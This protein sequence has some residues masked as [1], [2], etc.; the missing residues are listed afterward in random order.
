M[1]EWVRISAAGVEVPW[2]FSNPHRIYIYIY[3]IYYIY[4][5]L[6]SGPRIGGWRR[7]P[8]DG[9]AP[10]ATASRVR[11]VNI[12][13]YI[14]SHIY[15]YIL[16][17]TYRYAR[18][19]SPHRPRDSCR[20]PSPQDS[21][22]DTPSPGPRPGPVPGPVRAPCSGASQDR[23][24]ERPTRREADSERDRLGE[25]PT[26]SAQRAENRD[27]Q[28]GLSRPA[29]SDRKQPTRR[30]SDSERPRGSVQGLN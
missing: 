14:A 16:L 22:F 11:I 4:I 27:P 7:G 9:G 19:S 3:I 15:I 30:E 23:L 10:C 24:G 8:E 29:P 18:F 13:I 12:C 17:H 26:R 25:R 5:Y 6:F 28:P 20:R 1:P 21:Q 2:R